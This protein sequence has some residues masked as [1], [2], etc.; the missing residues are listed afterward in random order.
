MLYYKEKTTRILGCEIEYL[1]ATD[2]IDEALSEDEM[3]HWDAAF[4]Y[5]DSPEEFER[6]CDDAKGLANKVLK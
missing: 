6:L 1:S 4:S 2:N 3:K 5:G